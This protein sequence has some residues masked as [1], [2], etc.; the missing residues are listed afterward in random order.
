MAVKD[1]AYQIK[2]LKAVLEL[3]AGVG[4]FEHSQ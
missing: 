4:H 2:R 3:G 1:L